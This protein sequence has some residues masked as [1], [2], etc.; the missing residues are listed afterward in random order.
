MSISELPTTSKTIRPLLW[1]LLALS[2]TG[3]V[4]ASAAHLLLANVVLGVL[5]L[6]FGTALVMLH[7]RRR[8][9]GAAPRG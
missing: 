8:T 2:V 9:S 7:R 4:V 3:N 1:L 6:A 5:A